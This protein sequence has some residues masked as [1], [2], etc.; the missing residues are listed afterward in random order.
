[1]R[2]QAP[3]IVKRSNIHKSTLFCSPNCKVLSDEIQSSSPKR[4]K[5]TIPDP[6]A[7]L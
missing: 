3:P 1:M 5:P 7:E 2:E 6:G 4:K